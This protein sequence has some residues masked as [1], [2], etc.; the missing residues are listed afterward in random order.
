MET[1]SLIKGTACNRGR[2]RVWVESKRLSEFG[3]TRGAPITI[4]L[5]GDGIVVRLDPNGKRKVAGRPDKQ[6]LDI[7]FPLEQR[8]DMFC[9][10]AKLRVGIEQGLIVITGVSV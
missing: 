9:G 10:A 7:C 1:L 2:A 8:A 5:N 4:D 3:F 6:I